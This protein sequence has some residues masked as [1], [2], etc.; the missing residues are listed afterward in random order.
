[1]TLFR[2]LTDFIRQHRF[3]YA[4][5]ALLL[6]TIAG[7]TVSIPK[8]VG[9]LTDDLV[10]HQLTG[11]LLLPKLG[12]LLLC[13]GLIYLFRATW[14]LLL[15]STSY[16]LG[17]QLR[18]KLYAQ[19]CLQGPDFYH[20]RRTGDL[21]AL[22]TN[23]I[24]AVEMAAGEAFLAGFDGSLTLL[25]VLLALFFFVDSRLALVALIPFP[26]MA[27][28]FW[29]IS[30]HI[31]HAAAQALGYFG[32]LND[33]V[34]QSL[35]GIR[36]LRSLGL[37]QRSAQEFSRIA[38]QTA[39]ASFQ[40]QRWEAAF[41]PAVG[42]TL[43]VSSV[44]TMALG[45][46][47]VWQAQLSIGT[48]TSF[49]M[50]LGQLIW[51]MFAA[52]WVLSLIERAKAAW[53]R[54]QPVLEA[55]ETIQNDGQLGTLEAGPLDLQ[56][57]SF[58]YPGQNQNAL[59]DI[60]LHLAPGQTLGIVG[61]TGC[62]KSTLLRLLL[63]QYAPDTGQMSWNHAPLANYQLACLRAAIAWVPQ[64][65]FLFS[66]SIA[67]NIALA[68]PNA[69]QAE[70]E[71]V[72]RLAAI[73]ED[74]KRFPEGYATLVGERGITLS[75]GQRQRLAI[76]R[77]LLADSQ[78]L[79]L[80]DALSAVDTGTETAILQHL[81]DLRQKQQTRSVII[82]S[83][84]LSAVAESDHIIVLHNG[85]ISAQGNHAQLLAQA[86]WYDSQWRYQQLEA[87]LNAL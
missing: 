7:L 22:A 73:D 57:L 80:D 70:I 10:Q 58:R 28:A 44:L 51:P 74:I 43:A 2:L 55:A 31:H 16:Q 6:M 18:T 27:F 59:S 83:H 8:I 69:S 32:Q 40:A 12:L 86:G 47:L 54:L 19:L 53:L 81:S 72:A 14:R 50:Y 1:M 15:F 21:M 42:L 41:E 48:L 77:A 63:R 5:S 29:R 68:K 66:A 35:A 64:E 76:A 84:R 61:P 85:R 11:A 3:A 79:L 46:Y 9:Q 24:D 34:Q 36:T 62:G 23:D 4:T 82:A 13:G 78:L 56:A 39:Q 38:G 60:S 75:G 49:G 17:I 87:S 26:F 45:S 67:K 33:H 37:E 30:N 65:S 25:M 20:Q 52:G 71:E